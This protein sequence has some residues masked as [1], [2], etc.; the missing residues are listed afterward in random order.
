MKKILLSILFIAFGIMAFAQPGDAAVIQKIKARYSGGKTPAIK[1]GKASTTKEFK[2]GKW[3]YYYWRHY[4]IT[5]KAKDGK[6]SLQQGGAV[7][8]EKVG[9]HY[10]FDN[11]ATGETNLS[12]LKDP[13]PAVV[14][15]YLNSH[16]KEFFFVRYGSILEKEPHISIVPETKYKW[17]AMQGCVS[18]T[19]K[20]TF[21]RK[22]S[23]TEVELAE[24][25][26]EIC[27]YR[28]PLPDENAKWNRILASE[29]EGKKKVIS[30]KKYTSAEM[31]AIKTLQELEEENSAAAAISSLPSVETAPIFKSDKQLFYYIHD[32]LMAS[33]PQTAKAHLYKVLAKS[34]FQTGSILKNYVQDWVDKL[35]NNLKTYQYTFCQYPVVKDEQAG[36]IYF[37]N[38]D[39]SRF[40]RMTAKEESGT[41]KIKVIDYSPASQAEVNRLHKLVGNCAEKPDLEVKEKVSYQIGDIVDVH[42]SNGDYPAEIKKKDTSFDNRYYITFLSGGKSQWINDDQFSP[43]SVKKQTHKMGTIQHTE[44]K[45]EASFKVG[46]HVGVKTRSG[47][48][49]GKIVKMTSSKVLVKWDEAGYQDMW[50]S[51]SNLVKL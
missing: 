38:K 9:G 28:D 11:Y 22:V 30:K 21:K 17:I 27:L 51:P 26:F 46:D 14:T 42:Y 20:A 35:I 10:S 24:H 49:N 15:K 8:Y 16:L 37:Y 4:T 7:V 34:S 6:T 2:G 31:D 19:T 25:Y 32:R 45:K 41:W 39:K 5:A 18:F 1:L 43:S 50:T 47:V 3:H 48:M 33:A 12:G 44:V 40:V 29:I 23:G 13:D 36:M